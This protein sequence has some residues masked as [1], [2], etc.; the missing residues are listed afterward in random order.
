MTIRWKDERQSV[1][2][3]AQE[4][5]SLGLTV[6]TSGNVSL[7]VSSDDMGEP[8]RVLVA[9]TPTGVSYAEMTPQDIVVVDLDVNPVDGEG[10]PSSE[11]LLHTEIYRRRADAGA[12]IHTHS[13]FASVAAVMGLEMP[14]IIDEAIISIGGPVKVSEYAFPGSQELAD[15]VCAALE[16]RNAAIIRNHG[17]VCVGEDLREALNVCVMLE[18]LAQIYYYASMSGKVTTL[19]AD[20]VEA[21]VAIFEMRRQA[22]LNRS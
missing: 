12:V 10:I 22:R 9:I 18:R 5:A 16:G 7:R 14:P 13:V 3:A 2:T 11:T 1:V 19:P 21:E 8:D 17:A 20:V 4:M 15:N 6:G